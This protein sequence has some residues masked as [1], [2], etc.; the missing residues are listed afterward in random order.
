MALFCAVQ[1]PWSL[2]CVRK[3]RLWLINQPHIALLILLAVLYLIA[4][5]EYVYRSQ[6]V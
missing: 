2:I 1:I 4:G 5:V 3:S 6:N